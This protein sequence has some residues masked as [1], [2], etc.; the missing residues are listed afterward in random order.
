MIFADFLNRDRAIS[1]GTKSVC[2]TTSSTRCRLSSLT[3]A[4]PLMTRET[5]AGETPANLATS[6]ILIIETTST[7]LLYRLRSLFLK[8]VS[9]KIIIIYWNTIP[10]NS[11]RVFHLFIKGLSKILLCCFLVEF[12]N[13]QWS[14]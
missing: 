6:R 7:H 8:P 10:L 5:V 12:A 3:L 2:R 1:L 13:I 4:V 9:R 11:S 14:K